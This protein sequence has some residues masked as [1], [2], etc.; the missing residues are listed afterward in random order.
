MQNIE[1]LARG[2]GAALQLCPQYVRCLAAKE[3]N[4]A[5]ESLQGLMRELELVRMQYKHEATKGDAADEAQMEAYERQFRALHGEILKSANMQEYQEAAGELDRLVKRVVG[6]L[7]GCAQGED[8][9][10]YEPQD[11]CG[12]G[13]GGCKGCG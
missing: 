12:G 2:L 9:A 4:E 6:I 11:A 1:Q 5:D 10:S 3:Q 13:C 8:P 7:Q